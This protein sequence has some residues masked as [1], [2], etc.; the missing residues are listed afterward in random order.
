MSYFQIYEYNDHLYQ[1]KDSLGVLSTLIIGKDKACVI[2]TC[3]GI[4]DLKAEIKKITDKDLIVINTHGHMDHASGNY[5]FEEVYIHEKDLELIKHHTSKTWRQKNIN[6]AKRMNVLPENFDE[7][8]YL[9]KREGNLKFINYFDKFDLGEITCEILPLSGHTKGSIAVWI[10]EW[11]LLISSDGACPFVYMFF[12]ESTTVE[13][14]IESLENLLKYDFKEFLVG[15]G[16][17]K[18]LPKSRMEEFLKVAKEIDINKSIK[19]NASDEGIETYCYAN[20]PLYDQ[21]GAG[22]VFTPSK[23]KK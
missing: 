3:Y 18:L 4:Y 20:V 6:S 22:V 21:N 10:K 1:I 15:H 16:P 19:V 5:Q 2:D 7:Q 11:K 13:E 9:E 8:N 12:N 17:K 23:L 14:Y